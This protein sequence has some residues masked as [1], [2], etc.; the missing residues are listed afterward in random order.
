M[1]V[2]LDTNVLIAAFISHGSCADLVENVLAEHE[3]VTSEFIL[4]EF[5]EVLISK[6]KVDPVLATAAGNLIRKRVRIVI[7]MT[8]PV[9][10]CRDPDDD[11][12]LG[13]ATAGNCRY[14]VTGD[15]DL[16]EL[17]QY[18]DIRILPPRDFWALPD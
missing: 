16:L 18:G 14:L 6:F 7:P 3:C 17:N 2:V 10:V 12:V 11:L 13:T 4:G 9:A 1:R 5:R 8:L 15:K